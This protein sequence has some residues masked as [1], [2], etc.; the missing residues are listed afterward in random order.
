MMIRWGAGGARPFGRG[1][2]A[3]VEGKKRKLR[4][5]VLVVV[6]VMTRKYYYHHHLPPPD[7]PVDSTLICH[8][9]RCETMPWC[10]RCRVWAGIFIHLLVPEPRF[11][12]RRRTRTRKCPGR[13]HR[14][15]PPRRHP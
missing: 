11:R 3:E 6:V 4:K 8:P 2:G 14:H 10:K 13:R 5:V 7:V 15:S 9:K 12:A 1:D